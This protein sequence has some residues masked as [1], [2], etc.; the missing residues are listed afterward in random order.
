MNLNQLRYASATAAE[1]SFTK[2]AER[3]H[4]TQPTLSNGIAQLEEE[5][6]GAL[7]DRT[8]RKVNLTAFGK[9]V[10][11]LIDAVLQSQGELQARA[12]AFF[13]PQHQLLRIGLSPLIDMRLLTQVIAPY[14]TEFPDVDVFFKECFLDDLDA[15]LEKGQIDVMLCPFL[16]HEPTARSTFSTEI[17]T[18]ELRYL[19][20]RSSAMTQVDEGAVLLS[21]I[22][23]DTFILSYDGCGLANATRSLFSSADLQ[24]KEYSGH[25]MSYHVMQE[26]ADLGI[27]STILP[28][29]RISRE[30]RD[31]TCRVMLAPQHPALIRI[32]A[33]WNRAATYPKHISAFHQHLIERAPSL[34]R[35]AAAA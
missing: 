18:E 11:P 14:R 27:G 2:A 20:A 5:L 22:A 6:G 16:P 31:K 1:A 30:F 15:R 12:K 13:D 32:D 34:V 17:Y 25:T 29:S 4:V 33:L 19:S 3:C 8:T 10:L 7:F 24:L 35:G 23:D 28:G 26:W 21:Q 9:D